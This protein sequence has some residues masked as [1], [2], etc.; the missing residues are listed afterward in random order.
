MKLGDVNSRCARFVEVCSTSANAV[1][2]DDLTGS[3][4]TYQTSLMIMAL[5]A[6]KDKADFAKISALAQRLEDGQITNGNVGAWAYGLRNGGPLGGGDQSNTQ[7]AV[8]GLRDAADAG[9]VA[10]R[11]TWERIRRL[12]GDEPEPRWGLGVSRDKC[13]QQRQHDRRGSFVT[14]NH[15]NKCQQSDAG[16]AADGTPPCCKA[17]EPDKALQN[18]IGWMAR[19]FSV[20]HN[21]GAGGHSSHLYYVYGIERADGHDCPARDS[22]P[23]GDWYREGTAYLIGNNQNGV[24]GH[25]KG[26]G[27]SRDSARVWH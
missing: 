18:G 15:L 1:P 16:V 20:T 22:L 10:N 5:V 12:L 7:F 24:D 4:E 8:L 11:L 13:S 26:S 21:P 25:W 9:Y 14:G 17:P 27:I 19:N 2:L 23:T 3:I 6:A